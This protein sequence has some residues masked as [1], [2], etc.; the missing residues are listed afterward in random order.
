MAGRIHKGRSRRGGIFTLARTID[1]YGEV[2]DYDL[3]TRTGYTLRDWESGRL[4]SRSLFRF[5]KGL[6]S[7]SAF[8]RA[9]HPDD[10]QTLAWVNGDATCALIA[11]LIDVVRMSANTLAYKGTGKR[12]PRLE[13]YQRPW[14]R[15]KQQRYGRKPIPISQ[16]EKWYYGG[17][18]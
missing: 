14:N 7:D 3:L 10:A 18:D 1:K 13:P 9:S 12:P 11:E 17:G 6:G 5:I 16:F 15:A 4:D 2:V 8:Y